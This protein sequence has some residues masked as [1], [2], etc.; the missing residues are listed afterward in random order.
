M[1]NTPDGAPI[2]SLLI[3]GGGSAGWMAAAAL[4]HA[5]AG[6]C[7]ITL[8]ESP[9]VG[10]VGVGEATIPA[11]RHYN[12]RLGFDEA[13]F[14]RETQGSFKLG[15]EFDGW[16]QEGHR[17]FHPFG[18]HGRDFDEVSLYQYFLKAQAAGDETPL[19]EYSICWQ[20]ARANRFSPPAP[21]TRLAASTLDYAYHFDAGLYAAF[22]Q[23]FAEARGVRQI[24][25]T[26]ASVERDGKTGLVSGVRLDDGRVIS[27]QFFIDCSGFRSLVLG[28]ACGV[29][30][31]D[32]SHWLPCDRA[33]AMPCGR[34]GPL[35]PY[36]RSTAE[37]AGWRWRIPLQHRVGN[38]YVH[39]SRFISEDEATAHLIASVEGEA[40]A[41]PRVLHFKTGRRALFWKDN[42]VGIGL[43]A[44]FMEP[45]ES[46]SIHLI[47]SAIFRL[48]ELFPT[49]SRDLHNAA[50]F[51]RVTIEEWEHIRDFLIVHYHANARKGGELWRYCANMSLPESVA[52]RLA[53]Y[54]ATGRLMSH[55]FEMFK[56]SNWMSLLTGQAVMVNHY[57]PRA[58]MARI[59][60]AA[61]LSQMRHA[62]IKGAE[63][64]PTHEAFIE[65]HCRAPMH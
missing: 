1:T 23:R 31:L 45:L 13:E 41:D 62:L 59:D 51:N 52:A 60:S 20:A 35:S 3:V 27:A 29:P 50:E 54:R 25:A 32:W 21:D 56:E 44:G 34:S 38:G 14:V 2:R 57:D 37:E 17:Y 28:D 12:H 33:I 30:F 11:I 26:I 64:L 53:Y 47:Q 42:V 43:S 55:P 46:T 36:T 18:S 61:L 65:R 4:A 5:T 49:Q 16:R 7:D 40:H 24:K 9:V 6:G 58:D 63:K 10:T 15:I 22:L 48:I 19:D 39:C 8:V